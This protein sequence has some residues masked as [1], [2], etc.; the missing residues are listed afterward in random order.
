MPDFGLADNCG[1]YKNVRF[2]SLVFLLIGLVVDFD[3]VVSYT[4][5]PFLFLSRVIVFYF[6]LLS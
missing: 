6:F 3:I 5:A 2:A 1:D 4:V